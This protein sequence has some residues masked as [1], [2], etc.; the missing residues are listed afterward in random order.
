MSKELLFNNEEEK[1]F[2][3]QIM[4][5]LNGLSVNINMPFSKA[6][7]NAV[8]RLRERCAVFEEKQTDLKVGD[9][10]ARE[11]SPYYRGTIIDESEKYWIVKWKLMDDLVV[12]RKGEV[13][14][15]KCKEDKD[16]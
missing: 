11:A 15:K 9:M 2:W 8:L 6:A 12:Y 4:I 10:V 16:D 3:K 5:T 13:T 1:E 14:F 7:D